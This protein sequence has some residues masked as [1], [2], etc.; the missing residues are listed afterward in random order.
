MLT[1]L[2][3]FLASRAE[4]NHHSSSPT[5]RAFSTQGSLQPTP[6]GWHLSSTVVFVKQSLDQ[7]RFVSIQA[8][9]S[10]FKLCSLSFYSLLTIWSASPWP[11]IRS[12]LSTIKSIHI[13]GL[14]LPTLQARVRRKGSLIECVPWERDPSFNRTGQ[15]TQRDLCPVLPRFPSAPSFSRC[16]I[17]F[18]TRSVYVSLIALSELP[19]AA[20]SLSLGLLSSGCTDSRH[21]VGSR[22]LNANTWMGFEVSVSNT[23]HSGYGLRADVLVQSDS[24]FAKSHTNLDVPVPIT[25]FHLIVSWRTS[26]VTVDMLI[27]TQSSRNPLLQV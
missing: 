18:Q 16:P 6:S 14:I 26:Y 7:W 8:V 25:H 5:F 4:Y 1:R 2:K 22:N 10:S 12:F 13:N 23:Y 27:F 20:E 24:S 19:L 11:L 15:I 17:C 21:C 3:T 9:S